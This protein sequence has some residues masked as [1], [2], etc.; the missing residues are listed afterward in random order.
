MSD[1]DR[2]TAYALRVCPSALFARATSGVRIR[3]KRDSYFGEMG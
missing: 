1:Q 2:A 3:W